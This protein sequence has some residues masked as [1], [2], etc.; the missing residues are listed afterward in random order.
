MREVNAL[1][2][3]FGT[4][5]WL[6]RDHLGSTSLSVSESGDVLAEAKYTPWGVRRTLAGDLPTDYSYTGQREESALGLMYYVAR[7]YDSGIAHFVQADTIVPG[8]GNP[9]A[10]NRYAYVMYNPVRYVDPSGHWWVYG[11]PTIDDFDPNARW[12]DHDSNEGSYSE[13]STATDNFLSDLQYQ[14]DGINYGGNKV[15]TNEIRLNSKQAIPVWLEK[16][17]KNLQQKPWMWTTAPQWIKDLLFVE[18]GSG[19]TRIIMIDYHQMGHKGPEVWHINSDLKMLQNLNH[20]DLTPVLMSLV[21]FVNSFPK[22]PDVF[23]IIPY[24][25]SEGMDYME[26]YLPEPVDG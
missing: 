5:T 13:S 10:W 14:G 3:P 18:G 24:P 4:V 1:G 20:K 12:A 2:D 16:I 7:W 23:F 26:Q 21:N 11:D 22:F 6:L 8:A 9:A 19:G 25:L 17:L 15:E